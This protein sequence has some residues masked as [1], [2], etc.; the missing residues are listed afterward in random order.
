MKELMKKL[1]ISMAALLLAI[2]C[3]VCVNLY[4]AFAFSLIY[5]H[6]VPA[7]T[8]FAPLTYWQA[9]G[10]GLLIEL[11]TLTVR[12]GIAEVLGILKKN[13]G[14]GDLALEYRDGGFNVSLSLTELLAEAVLISVTLILF[15]IFRGLM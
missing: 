8:G 14:A 5:N 10:V 6:I 3:S 9:F 11:A 2:A 12:Y 4:F 7:A 13:F 15:V 1:A